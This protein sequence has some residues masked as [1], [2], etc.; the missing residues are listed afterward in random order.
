MANKRQKKKQQKRKFLA[1][2]PQSKSIKNLSF[3]ELEKRYISIVTDEENTRIKEQQ[4]RDKSK[5]KYDKAKDLLDYKRES[6]RALGFDEK[7]L[8]TS[9]L[10]KVKKADIDAFKNG[11]ESALSIENYPFLYDSYG[12]DFDKVYHFGNEGLY[13]AWLD[14]TGESTIEEVMH[15]F[16][17]LSNETLIQIL[18][19]IVHQKET[20]D[21]NA[22]NNGAG[23]SSGRAGGVNTGFF[24]DNTAKLMFDSDNAGIKK[25]Y[26]HE[27]KKRIHTATNKY[28]QTITGGGGDYTIKAISGRKLLIVLNA[29]FYNITEDTRL[30]T[31][32]TMYNGI[33]KRVPQF[34]NILPE[35]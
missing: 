30:S 15:R 12:F 32:K 19:G 3:N 20:Y 29:V 18:D 8:K 14:Y 1:K 9:Y 10:R 33:I 26:E 25:A 27:D 22:P 24:K 35:P 16:V 23:T 34:K 13:I 31:Y 4:K 28:Y 2:I 11:D 6:L 17:T 21:K 5:Q 7:F